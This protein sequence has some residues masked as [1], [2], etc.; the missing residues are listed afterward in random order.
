MQKSSY[1]PQKSI[2][3]IIPGL[4]F[5]FFCFLI[6]K[7]AIGNDAFIVAFLCSATFVGGTFCLF[8]AILKPQRFEKL[9]EQIHSLLKDL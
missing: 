9:F 5:F 6:N 7:F 1:C 3:W 8:K 4:M 2:I